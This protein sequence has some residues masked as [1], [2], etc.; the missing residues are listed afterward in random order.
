VQTLKNPCIDSR[1]NKLQAKFNKVSTS[2]INSQSNVTFS[3]LPLSSTIFITKKLYS[4]HIFL[5]NDNIF[6]HYVL[7]FFKSLLPL[8]FKSSTNFTISKHH[9]QLNAKYLYILTRK[10]ESCHLGKQP[11][12]FKVV[13]TRFARCVM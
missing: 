2:H 1:H 12:E 5:H 7:M 6:I 10:V 8:N 3:I 9:L 11:L 13:I 4:T